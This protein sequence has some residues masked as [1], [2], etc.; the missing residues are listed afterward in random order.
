MLSLLRS[1]PINF[2]ITLLLFCALYIDL[3]LGQEEEQSS[4]EYTDDDEF[5]EAVLN[6]TNTYRKQHNATALEWNETLADGAQ[7]WSERCV[8]EHS[9]C[10]TP[11]VSFPLR[12][13]EMA[14]RTHRRKSFF[15]L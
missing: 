13:I 4:T 15:G 8:F 10:C 9:V 3:A 11:L 1:S 7:E 2:L 5:K 12:L 14:G 6:V